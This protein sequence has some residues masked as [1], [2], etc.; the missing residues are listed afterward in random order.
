M[1]SS[2]APSTT[3]KNTNNKQIYTFNHNQTL[4]TTMFR[5]LS[6]QQPFPFFFTNDYMIPQTF[7]VT[8][9]HVRFYFLVFL[10]YTF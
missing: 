5:S 2:V 8:S 9:E 7:T 1:P 6:Q 4:F 10:F 3:R